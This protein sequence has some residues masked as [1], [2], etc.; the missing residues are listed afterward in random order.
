M[1]YLK[2]ILIREPHHRPEIKGAIQKFKDLFGD[3]KETPPPTKPPLVIQKDLENLVEKYIE[4][5]KKEEE[6]EGQVSSVRPMV[7]NSVGSKNSN[8]RV[9]GVH[10]LNSYNNSRSNKFMR[11][12]EDIFFCENI[13]V[14]DEGYQKIKELKITHIITTNPDPLL[15]RFNT[16]RLEFNNINLAH[17]AFRLAPKIS[18]LLREVLLLKGRLLFIND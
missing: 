15:A 10:F 14:N 5:L 18:D 16:I 6:K 13:N 2:S 7:V 11:I 3:M 8:H 9:R 12:M 17:L 1:E 4:E